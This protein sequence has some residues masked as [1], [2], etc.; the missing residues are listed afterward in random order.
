MRQA[1]LMEDDPGAGFQHRLSED[2]GEIDHAPRL[3]Q[4][5][6]ALAVFQDLAQLGLRGHAPV[7]SRVRDHHGCH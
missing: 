4:P 7:E 1:M 6:P 3:R 5:W 2:A